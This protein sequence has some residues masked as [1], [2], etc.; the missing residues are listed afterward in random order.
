[1]IIHLASFGGSASYRIGL[2]ELWPILLV[3]LGI[4]IL[5]AWLLWYVWW[6]PLSREWRQKSFQMRGTPLRGARVVVRS[7]TVLSNGDEDTE[8]LEP[9]IHAGLTPRPH[10]HC[11]RFTLELGISPPDTTLI[12][13]E[14]QALRLAMPHSARCARERTKLV[15]SGCEVLVCLISRGGEWLDPQQTPVFGPRIVRLRFDAHRSVRVLHLVYFGED[16]GLIDLS[17]ATVPHSRPA[18]ISI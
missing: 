1:M 18:G 15:D 12:S 17:L 3:V 14:P 11:Q 9:E 13:W 5:M 10:L 4:P 8:L 7:L 6:R 2:G 16:L